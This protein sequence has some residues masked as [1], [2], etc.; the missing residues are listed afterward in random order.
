MSIFLDDDD[1]ARLAGTKIKSR[2]VAQLRIMGI[3]FY[4]NAAGR[5]VVPRSA[6]E[7]NNQPLNQDQSWTP[8]VLKHG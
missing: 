2:Q 4:I 3:L 5:P 7:G 8:N 6:V 1:V